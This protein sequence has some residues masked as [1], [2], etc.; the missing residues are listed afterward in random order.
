MT[1]RVK[2][3]VPEICLDDPRWGEAVEYD[4]QIG[5]LVYDGGSTVNINGQMIQFPRAWLRR[6]NDKHND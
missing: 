3:C 4:Q 6:V 1:H 2:I 5:R